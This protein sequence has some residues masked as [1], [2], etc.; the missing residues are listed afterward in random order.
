MAS[1]PTNDYIDQLALEAEEGSDAALAELGKLAGKLGRQANQRMRRLEQ[2]GKTG[3]AY[4]RILEDLDGK[5]RFSQAKTGSAEGLRRNIEKALSALRRKESTIAGIKE[6]DRKTVESVFE[7]LDKMPEGGLTDQQIN[8]FNRFLENKAWPSIKRVF[9][10]DAL[11]Q[12]AD[13]VLQNDEID[14]ML[15]EFTA[16]AETPPEARRTVFQLVEGHLEF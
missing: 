1:L 2:A 8:D 14:D 5:K 7:T 3:D 15:A 11:K 6:V 9:G 4:K 10:S 12:I 16:W 13:M